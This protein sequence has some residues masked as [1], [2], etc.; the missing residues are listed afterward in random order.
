MT[1]DYISRLIELAKESYELAKK[2][3][4]YTET[5]TLPDWTSFLSK[6]NQLIGYISALELLQDKE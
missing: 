6:Y 5:K 2:T 3:P 1:K 4:I